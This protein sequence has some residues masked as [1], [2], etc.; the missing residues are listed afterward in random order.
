MNILASPPSHHQEI[1]P[2]N[3][4]ELEQIIFVSEQAFAEASAKQFDDLQT[5][6]KAE[7]ELMRLQT[8]LEIITL[9]HPDE[10]IYH[11]KPLVD[12]CISRL[13]LLRVKHGS[14]PSRYVHAAFSKPAVP[15]PHSNVQARHG[16]RYRRKSRLL[17]R[18]PHLH[19]PFLQFGGQNART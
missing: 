12:D 16:G 13:H 8:L 10:E 1:K 14:S 19:V 15:H 3:A 11:A 7:T 4:E 18:F 6:Q 17:S 9:T 5:V 2:E